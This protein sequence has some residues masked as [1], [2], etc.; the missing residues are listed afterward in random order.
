MSGSTKA[1][2][3]LRAVHSL[4]GVFPVGVFM[5][6]QLWAHAKALD[7]PEAHREAL[8]AVEPS[9]W[10]TGLLVLLPLAFHVGYGLWLTIRPRYNVG[11]YPLSRNW[12]Y[13]LQRVTGLLALAFLATVII[14]L[15]PQPAYLIHEHVVATLSTTHAGLPLLAFGCML[16]LGACVFHFAVGLWMIGVRYGFAATR[17]AQA[18]SG[19]AFAVIGI[20]LLLWSGHTVLFMATGW[21][22]VEAKQLGDG[23]V[24]CDPAAQL[25]P[26]TPARSATVT[27]SGSSP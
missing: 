27:P 2:F 21:A 6:M 20:A 12:T 16:G 3:G 22:A 8:L 15:W 23:A 9:G 14:W 26:A 18:Q 5:L 25:P 11:R 13:T 10:A 7:G 1:A 24:I 19:M 17:R 4:S